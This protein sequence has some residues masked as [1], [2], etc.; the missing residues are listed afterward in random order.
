MFMRITAVFLL[1]TSLRV[2]TARQQSDSNAYLPPF[3][4]Q[5]PPEKPRPF[6]PATSQPSYPSP[7]QRPSSLYTPPNTGY[8]SSGQ[9]TYSSPRPSF[10][11]SQQSSSTYVPQGFSGSSSYNPRPSQPSYSNTGSSAFPP[12][13]SPE[14]SSTYLPPQPSSFPTTSPAP[15]A[16]S[17][18]L[19]GF[20]TSS[21]SGRVF[22]TSS[23]LLF[24]STELFLETQIP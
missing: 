23:V 21:T 7:V 19:G 14:P 17:S 6:Q 15:Y 20:Q 18:S 24:R 12:L 2:V 1:S 3:S 11:S 13:S 5:R 16:G 9:P 22:N 10:P 8:P 4:T